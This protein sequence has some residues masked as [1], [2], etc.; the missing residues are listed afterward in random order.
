MSAVEMIAC[1]TAGVISILIGVFGT[2]RV[3]HE[4]REKEGMNFFLFSHISLLTKSASLFINILAGV[5][6]S[7]LLNHLL[8]YIRFNVFEASC[9]LLWLLVA[10]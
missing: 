5:K 8:C 9:C 2:P 4:A 1:T 7:F 10:D 6:G 3:T